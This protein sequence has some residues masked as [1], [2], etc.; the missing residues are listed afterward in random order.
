M[1]IINL[2]DCIFCQIVAKKIPCFQI[3]EDERTLAFPDINPL[4]NGHT[5]VISKNHVANLLEI[6]PGDLAAV[7]QAT[8]KIA[9]AIMKSL[10]STGITIMQLNG[11]GANQEIMHYHVHLVPRNR[12]N[13]GL[14]VLEWKSKAGNMKTIEHYARKITEVI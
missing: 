14:I 3:Y 1:N 4:T 9:H 8:Q 12:P 5:L 11:R 2:S 10:K 13:D 7:H 6:T